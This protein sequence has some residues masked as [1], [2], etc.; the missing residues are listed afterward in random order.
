MS[1]TLTSEQLYEEIKRRILD[2]EYRPGDVLPI[3]KLAASLGVSPTP[4]RE[5]LV[6]LES[7]RLIQRSPNNSARVTEL[8]Y[9]DLSDVFEV[10]MELEAFSGALAARRI[11]NEGIERCR[12]LHKE[13]AAASDLKHVMQID[14][15]LHNVVYT[16]TQN[17]M[18]DHFCRL[19]RH[20]VTHLWYLVEDEA[21]WCNNIT[22]EWG[23]MIASLASHDEQLS[24]TLQREHVKKFIREIERTLRLTPR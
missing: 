8:T 14:A 18:L 5:A 3:R 4:I 13:L 15:Q 23:E 2:Y 24:A 16:A 7:D 9:K 11:T 21:L 17:K 20:Q 19:L 1:D 6:R 10:R 12:A 22:E